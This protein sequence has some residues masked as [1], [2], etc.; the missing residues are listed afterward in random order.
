M[1]DIN[2]I[3]HVANNSDPE[4][5]RNLYRQRINPFDLRNLNFKIK[6]RIDKD[7]VRTIINLVK[8]DL[9]HSTRGSCTC[10]HMVQQVPV[11]AQLTTEN[12]SIYLTRVHA[13]TRFHIAC[14]SRNVLTLAKPLTVGANIAA[15]LQIGTK[16]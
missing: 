4:R 15:F 14:E 5:R 2:A 13:E 12:R 8:N 3:V 16:I 11:T 1:N 9:I 10:P 7:T 6:Y